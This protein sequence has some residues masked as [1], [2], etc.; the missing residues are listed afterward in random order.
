MTDKT[1]VISGF[2]GI[3]KSSAANFEDIVDFESS[4]F[5]HL[6]GGNVNINFP[7]NYVSALEFEMKT[8]PEKI[9]LISCHQEVRDEL[10]KRGIDYLIVM[11]YRDIRNEYMKR[12]LRRGSPQSFIKKMFEMWDKM[13]D[14]CEKDPAPK[15]YIDKNEYL[16]DVLPT[17]MKKL[18]K[19]F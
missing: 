11:P 10:K 3:G 5:S 16:R 18:K 14:S 1:Y 17:G 6:P 19:T 9:F 8:H 13:I 7:S 12:W 4:S 15:I 2:S